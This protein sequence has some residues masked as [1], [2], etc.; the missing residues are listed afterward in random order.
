MKTVV[1]SREISQICS[2]NQ[3]CA[4][5]MRQLRKY[6]I[7]FNAVN[8]IIIAAFCSSQHDFPFEY[9]SCCSVLVTN[10]VLSL[11]TTT[12][13][14]KQQQTNEIQNEKKNKKNRNNIKL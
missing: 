14:P 10:L 12:P 2:S 3:R 13:P 6:Y 11:F 4:I 9:S 1:I 8:Y 7:K 5:I